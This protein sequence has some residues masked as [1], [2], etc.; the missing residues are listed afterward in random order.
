[1]LLLNSW[2]DTHDRTLFVM[3]SSCWQRSSCLELRLVPEAKRKRAGDARRGPLRGVRA[4]AE[5]GAL[6]GACVVL[7]RVCGD[8][9]GLGRR[10]WSCVVVLGGGVHTY[11]GGPRAS[12][13]YTWHLVSIG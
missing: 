1:M 13:A 9:E 4:D 7:L 6:C 2:P 12:H 11:S 3:L 5:R 8:G 10:S